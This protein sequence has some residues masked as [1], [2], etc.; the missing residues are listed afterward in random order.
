MDIILVECFKKGTWVMWVD[1]VLKLGNELDFVSKFVGNLNIT[2]IN[3]LPE[4]D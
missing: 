2:Y 4:K 3:S 1:R